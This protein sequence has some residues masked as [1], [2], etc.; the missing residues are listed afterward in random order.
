MT[1]NVKDLMSNV[2]FDLILKKGRI[3]FFIPVKKSEREIKSTGI[4]K[5]SHNQSSKS[6][7]ESNQTDTKE[8]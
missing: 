1:V 5:N 8:Y 7:G 6:C 2:M 4:K 3:T